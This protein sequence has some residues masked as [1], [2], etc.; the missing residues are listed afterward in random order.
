MFFN[1]QEMFDGEPSEESD[2]GK[3]VDLMESGRGMNDCAHSRE[4]GE[5]A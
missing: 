3:A 5:L 1:F 2:S 4:V